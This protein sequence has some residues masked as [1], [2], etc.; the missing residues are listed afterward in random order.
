MA[1]HGFGRHLRWADFSKVPKSLD[2][3]SDAVTSTAINEKYRFVTYPDGTWKVT[4]VSV[5]LS[6]NPKESWVV[7]GKET[8]QLLRHEQM[9]Y[10]ISAIAAREL[11]RR[12]TGLKGDKSQTPEEAANAISRKIIGERDASGQTVL[13]GDLQ[14]VQTRYDEDLSCGSNHGL[15][16]HHQI[17][18][19][20]RIINAYVNRNAKLDQLNSCPREPRSKA[21]EAGE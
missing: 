1:L 2:G 13:S 15:D 9:H 16:R 4:N 21:A 8:K 6:F 17:I 7:K 19:E 11:E 5:A 20:H 18:W 10:D 3:D 14:Q 12:L